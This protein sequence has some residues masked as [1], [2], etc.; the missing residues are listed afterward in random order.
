MN[1]MNGRVDEKIESYK[2]IREGSGRV[3]DAQRKPGAIQER[4]ERY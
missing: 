1:G 4:N 3:R 2:G